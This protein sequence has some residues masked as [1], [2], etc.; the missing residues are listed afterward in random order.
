MN[1]GNF[2]IDLVESTKGFE[3]LEHDWR[4]LCNRAIAPHFFQSF[5]WLFRAWKHVASARGHELCIL[6][7]WFDG[8]V[9]LIWP[10]MRDGRQVRLLASEKTEYRGPLIEDSP[11]AGFWMEAAWDT[12]RTFKNVD[13][14]HF[15]DVQS[16]SPLAQFLDGQKRI[17]WKHYNSSRVIRLGRFANWEDYAMTLP[18][19]LR[20]DQRRQWR[21]LAARGDP[22][23]LKVLDS[24]EAI[25]EGLRWLFFHKIKW[26][27]INNINATSFES[28]DYISFI[29]DNI[30]N[31]LDANYVL[32]FIELCVGETVISA[33]YGFKSG[34]VFTMH[35]FTY[36][37][38]WQTYSPGRLLLE[39]M[40]Q[41][42]F[43]NGVVLYDFMPGEVSYKGI[44]ANDEFEVTDYLVPATLRGYVKAKL[45]ASGLPVLMDKKW[46]KTVSK[47]LPDGLRRRVGQTLFAYLNYAGRL[48]KL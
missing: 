27:K 14:F 24:K 42:C 47:C 15:Q 2:Q 6:V 38:A 7:G 37:K 43:Q 12:L 17:G 20:S 21:R 36:D 44:W 34:D 18:K 30:E 32:Y 10:L 45:C 26:M 16:S 28:P 25:E 29:R 13:M 9:V 22:V 4:D 40:V 33:G 31:P 19:K 8:R 3:A 46:L 23:R 39:S 48:E 35:N 1:A 5:D 11:Q 41:W